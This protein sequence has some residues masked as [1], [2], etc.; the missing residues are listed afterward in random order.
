MSLHAQELRTPRA[1]RQGKL[2]AYLKI[3]TEGTSKEVADYFGASAQFERVQIFCALAAYYTAEARATQDRNAANL[4]FGRA[5]ELL[6]SARGIDFQE[7]LVLL[8]VG[9]LALARVG[10][11]RLGLVV[12][13]QPLSSSARQRSLHSACSQLHAAHFLAP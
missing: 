7:Q 4:H 13:Q 5:A 11:P 10:H 8:A 1:S 6:N 3:L 12:T 2:P 9:Q